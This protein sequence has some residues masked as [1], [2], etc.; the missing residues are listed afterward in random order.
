MEITRRD[1]LKLMAGSAAGAVV[2]NGC[3]A[4][5]REMLMQSPL[6]MPEDMVTGLDNYYAS[7]C[8]QCPA[9]CGII[10]RVIE[11]KA[12]KIEGNP[13]YP[14]NQGKLCARGQ[15]GTQVLYHPDRIRGPKRLV[16]ARGSG[17]YEDITW[18]VATK[19]LASRLTQFQGQASTVAIM[20]EP[21]TGHLATVVKKF[22][23]SYGAEHIVFDSLADTVE[24]TVANRSFG[25]ST[26]PDLDIQNANYILSFGADFLGTWGSPVRY[27]KAYGEFRQ[28]RTKRGTLVQVEPRFSTTAASAD[29]WVPVSP[30]TEGILALSIAQVIISQGLGNS[31]AANTLTGGAGASRL[32]SFRPEDVSKLT[33]VSTDKII[34]IAKAFATQKP[35]LAIAGSTAGAH[36]NGVFNTSAIYALNYLVGSVSSPGGLVFNPKAPLPELQVTATA[37]ATFSDLERLAKRLL[38]GQPPVNLLM[39][40]NVNPVHGLPS[41]LGIKTGLSK[42]GYIVSFS[43]FMDETTEMADLILPDH[44]YLESWGDDIPEPGVGYEIVGLQQP[45]VNP[46]YNTKAFPDALLAIAAQLGGKMRSDLPWGSYL[47][48]IKQDAQKLFALNRGSV[49]APGFDAF[50]VGVLQR[51]GWWDTNAK[52]PAGAAPQVPALPSSAVAPS[53]GGDQSAYPYNL[54][55][56]ESISLSHGQGA[57]VPWLQSMADP[58][59]TMTW[60]TWVEVNPKTAEELKIVEGD[61]LIVESPNGA[62]RVP[63]YIHPAIPPKIVA[64]PMGQGHTAYGRYAAKR[65][66]NVFSIL[67]PVKDSE[68]GALAW[69]ATRVRL[70]KS[71]D[72]IKMPKIEGSV[73]AVEPPDVDIVGVTTG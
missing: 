59:T 41:S 40:H 58:V 8:R 29:E 67:S 53:F 70:T 72:K 20:T 37:A 54:I 10:V 5:E 64:I 19:E 65:G 62:I 32:N 28:G 24:R 66:Q 71:D 21:L 16:G 27:G 42:A 26:V 73:F 49:R 12:K 30:G 38:E 60:T 55:P 25:Q 35:S 61:V 36:S 31:A 57:N 1:F 7:I 13:D 46:L 34:E 69:A 50:W 52:A 23:S 51:G 2:F 43:S 22:A 14:V 15:A 39:V 11:G 63:A 44:T 56:F 48:L 68:T 3:N 47:D 18:E 4:P 45:V 33:G 9:G 17:Q 6:L